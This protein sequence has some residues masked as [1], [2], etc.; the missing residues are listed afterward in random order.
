L[1]DR[2]LHS[3]T[4]ARRFFQRRRSVLT[5]QV[6]EDEVLDGRRDVD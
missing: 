4:R 5:V 3:N 6:F 1:P 2:A